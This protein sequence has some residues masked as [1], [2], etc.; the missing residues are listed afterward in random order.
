MYEEAGLSI[1]E[2]VLYGGWSGR[3]GGISAQDIVIAR[4]P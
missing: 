1:V 3:P 4:K 2:P